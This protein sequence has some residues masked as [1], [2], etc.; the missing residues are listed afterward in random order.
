MSILTETLRD[1]RLG[2]PQAHLN[3][4]AFP[5]LSEAGEPPFYLTLGEALKTKTAHIDEIS[6]GGSVPEILFENSGDLPVL[7]LDGQELI[8]A[9][10][11][12]ILNLTIL[13]PGRSTL[14]IP[15]SCVEGGRWHWSRRDF[16]ESEDIAFAKLRMRKARAVSANLRQAGSRRADQAE[17]WD[18][19]SKISGD[20]GTSSHTAA[21]RDTYEQRR[22]V[23][24]GYVQAFPPAEKQVG[25]VFALNGEVTGVDLF[26]HPSTFKVVLPR[27]VRS[28]ALD[29]LS[30]KSGVTPVASDSTAVTFLNRIAKAKTK[31]Y[32]AIGEGEDM[33]IESEDLVG[34]AL[35]VSGQILHLCVFCERTVDKDEPTNNASRARA[36]R[37]SW[38]RAA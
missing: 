16:A 17:I 10:Q 35:E 24:N 20:L 29:A 15:V 9:K 25:V 38:Q 21:M 37:R 1:T 26:D 14:A 8:G 18:S 31:H 4:T 23:L 7:L 5:L 3:L 6:E 34:G 11:H 33:R 2:P 28:Q 36:R 22:D 30:K 13:V 32:R 19:I 12:R 27:L